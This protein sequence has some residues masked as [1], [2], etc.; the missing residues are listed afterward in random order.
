MTQELVIS[1]LDKEVHKRPFPYDKGKTVATW[2]WGFKIS[3]NHLVE[4]RQFFLKYTDNGMFTRISSIFL[5]Q[6]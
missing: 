2:A 1:M 6:L 4:I 3:I 5:F